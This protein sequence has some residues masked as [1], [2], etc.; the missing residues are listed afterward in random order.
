MA[1]RLASSR[2]KWAL[3]LL[4]L[5]FCA[6]ALL[7]VT[8]SNAKGVSCVQGDDGQIPTLTL[9]ATSASDTDEQRLEVARRLFTMCLDA[10]KG[11]WVL[12]ARL[13]DYRVENAELYSAPVAPRPFVRLTYSVWPLMPEDWVAGNGKAD[14][15]WI[16][17]KTTL[18]RL[19]RVG[20]TYWIR[21]MGTGP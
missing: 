5:A 14:G 18:I 11:S 2:T 16:A 8:N 7:V 10:Y 20:D 21:S 6:V 13:L 17:G 1:T 3:G 4:T 12:S 19:S 9:P 15:G